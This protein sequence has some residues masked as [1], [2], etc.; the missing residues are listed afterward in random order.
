MVF[1]LATDS[2]KH[3]ILKYLALTPDIDLRHQDKQNADHNQHKK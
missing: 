1:L 2:F 3:G